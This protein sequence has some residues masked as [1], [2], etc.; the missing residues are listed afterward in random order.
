MSPEFGE[1]L[2]RRMPI[3]RHV[4][5]HDVANLVGFLCSPESEMIVGQTIIL[6]GGISL[7]GILQA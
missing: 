7:V 5:P 1:N 3:G 4:T 6:D 2:R